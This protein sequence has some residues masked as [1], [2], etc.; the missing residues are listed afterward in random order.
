MFVYNRR[1]SKPTEDLTTYMI[2]QSMALW[3]GQYGYPA[4]FFLLIGGIIGVPVP[5][6][7]LLVISGYLILTKALAVAPTLLAAVLGSICG[8]TLSY[9]IG[10][11]SG[12]YLAKTRFAADRLEKAQKYFE[13]FGGWTLIFG[14]FVPGIRN[15]IGFTSGVMR[16]KPRLF[17]PFAYAGAVVSSITCVALGYFL[18]SQASWVLDSVGWFALLA[19]AAAAIFFIRRAIRTGSPD[20]VNTAAPATATSA[21]LE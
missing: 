6:Q 16:L 20:I 18:G 2:Q 11:C 3:I 4:I 7:L 17:A 8:I 13:R 10:R 12:S 9:L 1:S 15:L 5:D 19:I 21:I 14:Y